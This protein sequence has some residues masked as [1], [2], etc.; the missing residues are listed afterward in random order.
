MQVEK[1]GSAAHKR[2]DVVPERFRVETTD[3]RKELSFATRPL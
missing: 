2:L 3:L 1:N